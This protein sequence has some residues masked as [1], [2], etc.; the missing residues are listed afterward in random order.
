VKREETINP[1]FN[2][3][4]FCALASMLVAASVYHP[5]RDV[6]ALMDAAFRDGLFLGRLDAEQGRKPQ[7]ST[8]RWST[9][10]DRRLF[11]SGYVQAYGEVFR[12]AEDEPHAWQLAEQRGY[13]DGITDGVKQRRGSNRFQASASENYA[14]A[15]RGFSS[16]MGELT[17]YKQ[18][19]RE[20]YCT[21]YQRGYYRNEEKIESAKLTQLSEP[22]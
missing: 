3:R 18:L 21:G 2:S 22:E 9:D 7:L 5:S 15:D 8:G 11:V 16:R 6:G 4:C 10:S 14:R 19:Y 12:A 20:A 1:C 13:R 17:Q